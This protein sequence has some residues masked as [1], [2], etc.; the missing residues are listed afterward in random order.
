MV[1]CADCGCL[2]GIDPRTK[3]FVE[4]QTWMRSSWET[5]LNGQEVIQKV[6]RCCKGK[7][8][9]LNDLG[10]PAIPDQAVHNID[11]LN[12]IARDIGDCP[13]FEKYEAGVSPKEDTSYERTKRDSTV[14]R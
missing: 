4:V 14:P 3:D 12:L 1:R 6:P 2:A 11:I 10:N 13:G 5:I 8:N 7:R 9:F